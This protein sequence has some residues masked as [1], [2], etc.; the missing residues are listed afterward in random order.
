[1]VLH[2]QETRLMLMFWLLPAVEV[3]ALLVEQVAQV[4]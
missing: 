1:M 3:L 4:D 2:L